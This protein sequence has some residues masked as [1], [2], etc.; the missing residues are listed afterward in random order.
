[1]VNFMQRYNKHIMVYA[2]VLLFISAFLIFS[3]NSIVEAQSAKQQVCDA[4]GNCSDTGQVDK[5]I[6]AVVNILSVIVGIVAVIMIVIGGF[7]YITSSGD[8][9]KTASARNTIIYAL[10]GLIIVALAQVIVR[11][12]L[13]RATG[14]PTTSPDETAMLLL[15]IFV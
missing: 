12:V 8:A 4:I 2:I 13:A 6:T 5:I 7:K 15:T 3:P 14:N 10:V 9:N 1:M 11:F